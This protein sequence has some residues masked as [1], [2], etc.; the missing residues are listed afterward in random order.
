MR[1]YYAILAGIGL[2]CTNTQGIVYRGEGSWQT[3]KRFECSSLLRAEDAVCV[4][5]DTEESIYIYIHGT[6]ASTSVRTAYNARFS[7]SKIV[8]GTL[9]SAV[10]H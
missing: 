2:Y 9:F 10:V 8:L 6:A 4:T 7:S 3:G 5:E 1:T